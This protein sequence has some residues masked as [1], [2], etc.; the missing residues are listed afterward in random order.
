MLLLVLILPF[1]T[2]YLLDKRHMSPTTKDL[3]LL[4][5]SGVFQSLGCL[6]VGFAWTPAFLILGL[7]VLALGS[8]FYLIATS[9]AAAM[10]TV[11]ERGVLFTAIAVVSA[12]GQLVA[13]PF[14][15]GTFSGGLSIGGWATGLPFIV[16][17]G[18]FASAA[19]AAFVVRR[20]EVELHRAR[21]ADL[22]ERADGNDGGE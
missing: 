14:L 13:G 4:R 11:T 8:A 3:T 7:I 15:A 22:A 17:G 10:V 9:L 2:K 21:I 12:A 6:M 18:L 5:I 1:A 19:L 20:S 16:A